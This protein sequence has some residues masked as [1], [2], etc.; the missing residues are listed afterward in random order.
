M[1]V[2]VLFLRDVAGTAKAGDIREVT[3]GYARNYLFPRRFAV[4][5]DASTVAQTEKR[6]ERGKLKEQEQ[7]AGAQEAAQRLKKVTLTV[8]AKAG[9]GGRLFGAVTDADIASQL[10]RETGLEIDKKSI[11]IAEPIKTLGP[12]ELQ[13]NLHPDVVASLRVVVAAE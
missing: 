10:K 12:Q 1:N 8:Y 9:D 2:K 7:L 6:I 5:A 13:I 4:A 11:E 3:P